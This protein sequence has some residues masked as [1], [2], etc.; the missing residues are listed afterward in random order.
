ME[1][2]RTDGEKLS[3]RIARRT[4]S[5]VVAATLGRS[6]STRDTVDVETPASCATFLIDM[7]LSAK[8]HKTI[9]GMNMPRV[10]KYSK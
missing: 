4:D 10:Q 3:S 1:P 8:P 2:L 7:W 9:E 6:F 5:T